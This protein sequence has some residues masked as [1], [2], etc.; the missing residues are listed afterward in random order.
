MTKSEFEQLIVGDRIRYAR[1]DTANPVGIGRVTE[2]GFSTTIGHY[3]VKIEWDSC[4]ENGRP[5][6]NWGPRYTNASCISVI[7]DIT[8]IGPATHAVALG[9]LKAALKTDTDFA[10][11]IQYSSKRAPAGG[12]VCK[13]CNSK[14]EY[15]AANQKDGSYLC[16]E[17]R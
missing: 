15:A 5:V 11:A 6:K 7:V 13:R 3:R 4:E 9:T 1:K 12:C 14:N 8:K 16:Y 10:A 17:C 2:A